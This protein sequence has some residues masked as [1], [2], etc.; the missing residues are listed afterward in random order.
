MYRL[1]T[2]D[3]A[4]DDIMVTIADHTVWKYDRLMVANNVVFRD[5]QLRGGGGRLELESSLK[6]PG[7]SV[8]CR[9]FRRFMSESERRQLRSSILQ[10]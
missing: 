9:P 8:S 2:I 6:C 1:A 3:F 7:T 4:I 10:T 5:A